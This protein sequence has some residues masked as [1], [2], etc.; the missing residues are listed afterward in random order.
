[1]S[2]RS[3]QPIRSAGT[4]AP[5]APAIS[6]LLGQLG[7]DAAV[8]PNASE[9]AA[10]LAA[11][12]RSHATS[13]G[14]RRRSRSTTETFLATLLARGDAGEMATYFHPGTELPNAEALT[15]ALDRALVLDSSSTGVAVLLVG[16]DGLGRVGGR[17]GPIGAQEVVVN[18]AA[19]VRDVVRDVDLVAHCA[20]DEF[21]VLLAGV[22]SD[23][24]VKEISGRMERAFHEPLVAVGHY[25][26]FTATVGAALAR[27]GSTATDAL[28]RGR[29]ALEWQRSTRARAI[30]G[31]PV[32]GLARTA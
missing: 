14:D 13:P 18:A 12:S 19:R 21:A 29:L 11:L 31:T 26:Y 25:V 23:E 3:L 10:L 28:R 6:A 7:I 5:L 22:P 8:P 16:L 24:S 1:M 2:G 4:E 17:L 30:T 20:P 9:W 15:E 27:P 32:A